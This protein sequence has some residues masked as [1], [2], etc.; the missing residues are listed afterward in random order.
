MVSTWIKIFGL[1]L[2]QEMKL[3]R[4]HLQIEKQTH[5]HNGAMHCGHIH[6]IEHPHFGAAAADDLVQ[7]VIRLVSF[8]YKVHQ[9]ESVKICQSQEQLLQNP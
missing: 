9:L 4:C 5:M 3:N 6:Q 8:Q 2:K 1:V 7:Q